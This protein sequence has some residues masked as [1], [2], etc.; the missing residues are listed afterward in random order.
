MKQSGPEEHMVLPCPEG[1]FHIKISSV[2]GDLG[3]RRKMKEIRTY[4]SFL[5]PGTGCS[6]G[7]NA[8]FMGPGKRRQNCFAAG[9]CA[10]MG[11][12]CSCHRVCTVN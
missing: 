1:I 4:P 10:G 12:S 5:T 2:A 8:N 3:Q 7:R 6:A 9:L 11:G